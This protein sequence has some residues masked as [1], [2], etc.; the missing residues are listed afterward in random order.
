VAF[1]RTQTQIHMKQ[2]SSL[3]RQ[4]RQ[5]I[6]LGRNTPGLA[7]K[8]WDR[9]NDPQIKPFLK[10][11][12]KSFKK[13]SREQTLCKIA[14]ARSLNKPLQLS[15]EESQTLTPADWNKMRPEILTTPHADKIN[16]EFAPD[17]KEMEEKLLNGQ[18][19]SGIEMKNLDKWANE[20]QHP[21]AKEIAQLDQKIE[22]ETG[23][24]LHDS[25]IG[26]PRKGFEAMDAS[27]KRAAPDLGHFH[28]VNAPPGMD[29]LR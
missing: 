8:L 20:K 19:L 5:K 13:D 1:S 25:K 6:N 29:H 22:K 10:S 18:K 12:G 17:F 7:E 15:A 26:Q 11:L 24:I 3:T 23:W 21:V 16:M 9:S 2:E 28:G 27:K 4:I 14:E